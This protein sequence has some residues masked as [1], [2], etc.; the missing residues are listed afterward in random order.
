M[1]ERTNFHTTKHGRNNIVRQVRAGRKLRFTCVSTAFKP[2][3]R[4]E[5]TISEHV[6]WDSPTVTQI[7]LV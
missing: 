6:T 4:Q 2:P 5:P 3:L 7:Y 1:A